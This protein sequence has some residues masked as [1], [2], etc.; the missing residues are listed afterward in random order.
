MNETKARI[1]NLKP[2]DISR[3]VHNPNLNLDHLHD[4]KK[5]QDNCKIKLKELDLKEPNRLEYFSSHGVIEEDGFFKLYDQAS[6][7]T[8]SEVFIPEGRYFSTNAKLANN[9][10]NG[11]ATDLQLLCNI[12]KEDE[13]ETEETRKPFVNF[14]IPPDH[15]AFSASS[16]YP[17]F[18]RNT[19]EE[20]EFANDEDVENVTSP[21][22]TF[23]TDSSIRSYEETKRYSLYFIN[24]F[25]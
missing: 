8:P 14:Q 25:M 10:K 13:V 4:I 15:D 5:Q 23:K 20:F 7:K 3:I 24:I 6:Y 16:N 21:N 19:L 1:Q 17:G 12:Q 2:R 9:P 11:V 18:N 22:D